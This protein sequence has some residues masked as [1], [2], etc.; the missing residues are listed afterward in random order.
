[1]LDIEAKCLESLEKGNTLLSELCNK[2]R[3]EKNWEKY[4][5][6]IFYKKSLFKT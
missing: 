5:V 4:I 6:V 1:M 2:G 3:Y